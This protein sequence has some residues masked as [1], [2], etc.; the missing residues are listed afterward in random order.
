[1]STLKN[2][3]DHPRPDPWTSAEGLPITRPNLEAL[4][5]NR[6]PC[7]RIADFA[8]RSECAALSNAAREAR[9]AY[10]AE[11]DP[12]IGRI[13]VALFS[14]R[15]QPKKVYF[16][17]ASEQRRI[18]RQILSRSFDP[19]S[20]LIKMLGKV[21]GTRVSNAS[22]S[23]YGSFFFGLIRL[24]QLKA[25]LH[26]DFVQLDAP[27]SALADVEA[28]LAWNLY[29]TEPESGGN[30]IVYNQLWQPEHER[31]KEDDSRLYYR[32]DLVGHCSKFAIN[33]RLGDLVIFNCRNLHEIEACSGE[34][35]TITSF[36][37]RK[38]DG[39]LVLWS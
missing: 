13:G 10:D 27:H 20:R 16:Q 35:M 28:Q 18:Q 11:V 25:G 8:T 26:A 9:F 39:E 15:D 21:S 24:I 37:G 38:P 5:E 29:L 19:L 36:I 31:H 23:E 34:R 6:I 30:C 2:S 14:Y 7:I 4:L 1:M 32:R 12:P 17:V 3:S 22:D 33:P